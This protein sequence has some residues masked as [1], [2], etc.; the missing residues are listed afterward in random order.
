MA[1]AVKNT[2][3]VSSS[4]LDR[5]PVAS[6]VGVLYVLGSL[7]IVFGLLPTLWWNVLGFRPTFASASVLGVL[8]VAAALGLI[9]L[10]GRGPVVKA[11]HGTRAGIF[12]GILGFLVILLLT[13]WVSLWVEHWCFDTDTFSPSAGIVIVLVVGIAL[14]ASGLRL[15][16]QPSTEKMLIQLEDQGWFHATSYKSM[17]GQRVRRGTILGI[18]LLAITGIYTL[19][20]HQILRRGSENWEL[21]IPFTG[22]VAV[23]SLGDASTDPELAAKLASLKP[24]EQLF[25]DRSEFRQISDRYDPATHVKVVLHGDSTN[26][27]DGKVVTKTAYETEKRAVEK[28]DGTLPP[29]VAPEPPDG[30]LE[31]RR[32]VLLPSV[33]YTVPLLILAGSIWLAWRIVNYPMFADFLIATEAEMNK[34]SWTSRKNLMKDTIVVLVTMVLMAGFLF[35]TDLVWEVLLGSKEI[36]VLQINQQQNQETPNRERPLW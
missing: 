34:V 11:P 9:V 2:P 19:T 22:Q 7:G 5:L 8:M 3:E 4:S 28:N 18:L 23:S 27:E 29:P 6:L 24:G 20:S 12:V 30:T 17:Q 14:L 35:C 1:V 32:L 26:F 21:N 13:R 25:L 16:F 15:F 36:N 33:Q 31:Y 10:G